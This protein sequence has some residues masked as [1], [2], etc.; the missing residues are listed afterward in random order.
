MAC[1]SFAGIGQTEVQLVKQNGDYYFNNNNYTEALN[2]YDKAIQTCENCP[3]SF[4]IDLLVG[5]GR[6]LQLLEKYDLAYE[7]LKKAYDLSSIDVSE[8]PDARLNAL[9]SLAE[10]HRN[11]R[12][13]YEA[14]L[15]LR[16]C[17]PLVEKKEVTKEHKANYY[18]RFAAVINE[19]H[20]SPDS[21]I[22]L[23]EKA[24]RY[25]REINNNNLIAISVNEISHV[26]EHYGD[27]EK[28]IIGYRESADLW[29]EIKNNRAAASALYNLSRVYQKKE[30]YKKCIQVADEAIALVYTQDWVSI[31]VNLYSIKT[32][33]LFALNKYKD[34]SD[35]QALYYDAVLRLWE[36]EKND[37]MAEIAAELELARKNKALFKTIKN[38]RMVQL[39]LKTEQIRFQI[40]KQNKRDLIYIV[41]IGSCLMLFLMFLTL[42]SLRVNRRLKWLVDSRQLLLKEVHHRVKNNMQTVSSLLDLQTLFVKDKVAINAI[43]TGKDRINSLALAHQNLYVNNRYDSIDLKQYIQ[44]I[45][46]SVIPNDVEFELYMEDLDFEI[47]KAQSV[48]F[49]VNEL[50]MN[51]IKHAWSVEAT[52]KNIS[53]TFRKCD[54]EKGRTW[55]MEYQDNGSGVVDKKKFKESPTFGVT[56]INTFLKRNLKGSYNFGDSSGMHLCF[57]F[58]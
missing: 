22:F 48:G 50:M 25:A 29:I 11:R 43:Q 44:S 5:K 23:S 6:S 20:P 46:S 15:Y 49:I 1:F 34:G 30:N 57:E 38:N 13:Y 26:E 10:Y 47:E 33:A 54:K 51:S 36:K 16:M 3:R 58:N 31:L 24:L 17:E 19:N 45:A 8:A 7:S 35:V 32:Q 12:A 40:A 14:R 28:A 41:I 2:Q 42:R 4:Q 27:L 39:Q 56:I 18:N 52:G 37:G 53:L 9:V 55:C 21:V